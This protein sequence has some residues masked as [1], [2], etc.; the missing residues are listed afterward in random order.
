MRFGEGGIVCEC[1]LCQMLA[2]RQDIALVQNKTLLL[3]TGPVQTQDVIIVVHKQDIGFVLTQDI[4]LHVCL[5]KQ[6]SVLVR[7]QDIVLIQEQDMALAQE[8]YI[9]LVQNQGI[10]LV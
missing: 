9:V 4:V 3:F 1:N 2:Q 5:Q 6:D 7:K 10:V 8:Q